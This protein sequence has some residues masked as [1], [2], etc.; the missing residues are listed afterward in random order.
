MAEQVYVPEQPEYSSDYLESLKSFQ[1]RTNVLKRKAEVANAA[2]S[3]TSSS[4]FKKSFVADDGVRYVWD[5]DEDDWVEG[6]E[7]D[8]E[9]DDQVIGKG[10]DDEDEDGHISKKST[11]TKATG[12]A[13]A[14][15]VD[16]HG[17][18]VLKP[19]RVR[20]NKNKKK[21]PV[22][23]WVYITGLPGDITE[24][25]LKDHF[26]RVGMLAINP[27]DQSRKVKIYKDDSGGCKGDGSVCFACAESVDMAVD[28]LH[29]GYIRP[30]HRIT[31]ARAE[32]S[33]PSASS[34]GAGSGAAAAGLPQRPALTKAQIN[35]ANSATRQALHW[36]EE[37][38]LGVSSSKALKIVVIQGMFHPEDLI[39]PGSA[40]LA[41]G[42]RDELEEEDDEQVRRQVAFE[43]EILKELEQDVVEECTLKCGVIDKITIFSKHPKGIII[44]RFQT[45]FA[46]EACVKLMDGRW[47]D[48]TQLKCFY[49]DGTTNYS[50]TSASLSLGGGRVAEI[51]G[52]QEE[53]RL[54][55]FG[56][57]LDQQDD[58]PDEFKLVSES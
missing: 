42:L 13:P 6:D 8:D 19:K 30:S 56:S 29:E 44:V 25:E 45:A 48:K 27:F 24:D 5:E 58:L 53:R 50:V 9:I 14:R 49:W 20:K 32:F 7:S 28:I 15:T 31:V 2:K 16:E 54:E 38:D 55:A 35:V 34:A 52:V 3:A 36:N 47:Y 23:N 17:N 4:D 57:W 12:N 21:K 41:A 33:I 10:G 40:A 37:G 39:C 18:E 26:S 43:D 1:E 46:A 22:N 11:A 51:E